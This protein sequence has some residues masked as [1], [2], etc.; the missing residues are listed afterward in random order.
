MLAA[1]PVTRFAIAV[2]TA[3]LLVSAVGADPRLDDALE[4]RGARVYADH[5]EPGV[6]YV[7]PGPIAIGRRDGGAPAVDL[8]LTY[9]YGSSL[10]DDRG[11]RDVLWGL[12]IDLVR[13]M[14]GTAERK[15]LAEALRDR[16]P[17]D[18]PVVVRNLPVYG[19]PIEV[20]YSPI[21]PDL[22]EVALGEAHV[23]EP[24]VDE[25]SDGESEDP[26][27]RDAGLWSRR[28][29]SFALSPE[30]GTAMRAAFESGG[31]LM[32][33]SYA[34]RVRGVV[35]TEALDEE[36]REWLE[37]ERLVGADAL[38]VEIDGA[39]HPEFLRIVDLNSLAPPGYAGLSVLCS[40]FAPAV[41]DWSFEAKRVE[42]EA[43]G[44]AGQPIRASVEFPAVDPEVSL[45][46]VA[47][48][49][50][51][52]VDR[53]YRYR[54]T[55]YTIEGERRQGPWHEVEQWS[56]PLDITGEMEGDM[57]GEG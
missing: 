31:A 23:T 42:L 11:R 24:E 47:F 19:M 18:E 50:A 34:Y 28:R 39:T 44:V 25:P 43:E 21:D 7:A 55:A 17:A 6:F 1:E 48:P 8:R 51:V 57:G 9:Y 45:Q 41:D 46:R 15:A 12:G 27:A 2:S 49:Y 29:L 10:R 54:V 14:P 52:R 36:E 20:V 53:P 16:V 13:S 56:R 5:E 37:V 3:L 33:I 38:R 30:D 4:V 35:P 22:T 32:G 40:D 26:P